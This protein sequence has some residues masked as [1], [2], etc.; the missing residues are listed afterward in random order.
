[1]TLHKHT[2]SSSSMRSK[3]GYIP[4]LN[5]TCPS[6]PPFPQNSSSND[7][8]LIA[9]LCGKAPNASGS[10]NNDVARITPRLIGITILGLAFNHAVFSSLTRTSGGTT[11]MGVALRT[12]EMAV[13]PTAKVA[14]FLLLPMLCT[15]SPVSSRFFFS[16]SE[17][18]G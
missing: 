11:M 6:N 9:C 1:M 16:S 14:A 15:A 12:R 4:R 7:F 3:N 17:R 8:A 10:A 5:S 18:T 13:S 2:S